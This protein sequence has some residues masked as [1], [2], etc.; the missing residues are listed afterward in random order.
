[1]YGYDGNGDWTPGPPT[2]TRF[3]PGTDRLETS[4]NAPPTLWVGASTPDHVTAY[5]TSYLDAEVF[6]WRFADWPRFQA[7]DH[8][9]IDPDGRPV[10]SNNLSVTPDKAHL[11][12]AGTIDS[13]DNWY[14]GHVH[15]VWIY[16]IASGRRYLA[17]R[18]DDAVTASF[19]ANA[20]RL[21]LY[22][23][24]ADTRDA[25]GWI[26]IGVQSDADQNSEARLLALRVRPNERP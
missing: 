4:K 5:T 16:E 22:W 11:V 10:Y 15:G 17:A 21:K 25:A 6:S 19:G 9:R 8:G 14:L 26:Y 7:V 2:I 1:M 18:L 20:R 23:T 13:K 3:D 12:V 24:N